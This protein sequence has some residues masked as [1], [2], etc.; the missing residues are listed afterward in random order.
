MTNYELLEKLRKE[1]GY[2]RKRIGNLLN[3]SP[4]TIEKYE[5]GKIKISNTARYI[6]G[7]CALYGI[8]EIA[9]KYPDKY[10]QYLLSDFSSH[11]RMILY[12]NQIDISNKRELMN[13]IAVL[14]NKS[15]EIPTLYLPD[16]DLFKE[17]LIPHLLYTY[18]N[19]SIF[20]GAIA[21]I[22]STILNF[23]K[24]SDFVGKNIFDNFFKEYQH[25]NHIYL[26]VYIY[27]EDEANC[28]E[29]ISQNTSIE[30]DTSFLFKKINELEKNGVIPYLENILGYNIFSFK[31]KNEV[32]PAP[33]DP[34]DK[35]ICE[36]LQYAPPAF[37]DKIIEKLL[38]FK[39]EVEDI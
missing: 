31:T 3:I 26:D 4:S 33:T 22:L 16:N 19:P 11:M 1:L 2:S 25:K 38:K 14:I 35:Q 24:I 13:A 21:V 7:I 29:T 20:E 34:K 12:Y 9:F 28:I 27:T 32:I 6:Q 39:D 36:L 15:K 10:K 30:C 17:Y 5:K 18:K 8:S 37:K 23:F